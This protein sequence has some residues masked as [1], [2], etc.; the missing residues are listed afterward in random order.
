MSSANNTN[1]LLDTGLRAQNSGRMDEAARIFQQVLAADPRNVRALNTYGLFLEKTKEQSKA[2]EFLRRA[3]Q[4]APHVL[5]SY[6]NLGFVLHSAKKFDSAIDCC[7]LGLKLFPGNRYLQNNLATNLHSAGKY[8]EAIDLLK[9]MIALD[10]SHTGA[11][12]HIG[13]IYMDLDDSAEAV[14]FFIEALQ[15]NPNDHL[16]LSAAGECLLKTGR[17]GEALDMFDK[18]LQLGGFDNRITSLKTLTLAELGRTQEE[19][20][21]SDPHRLGQISIIS[22][23]GYSREDMLALNREL[24]EFASNH[25]TLR[26]DPKEN[27]AYKSWHSK[28]IAFDGN[29]AVEKLKHFIAYACDKRLKTLAQEDPLH[30]FVKTVPRESDLFLWAVKMQG[31]GQ[32]TPHTHPAG[33]LSGVY[34]VDIPDVVSA[35]NSGEAGWLKLG[36]PRA[37]FKLTRQPITRAVKPEPGMLVTFPS[38]IWHDTVPLPE[39]TTQ[40]RLCLAFDIEPMNRR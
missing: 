38:Y 14:K 35:A 9:K 13:R 5:D 16:S 12:Y 36:P 40:Q 34:Y 19:N 37:D 26:K 3:I 29:P 25:P 4:Y 31:G 22:E 18:A 6:V 7:Q 39:D 28:N 1:E 17:A 27:A 10:P 30:P 23:I 11:R 21:L 33:W 32:F 8:D 2:E 20:W 15:F 24:S